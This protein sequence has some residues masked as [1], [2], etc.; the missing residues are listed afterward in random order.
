M[1]DNLWTGCWKTQP[2]VLFVTGFVEGGFD[3]FTYRM[4]LKN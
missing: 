3:L 2:V 4:K 1:K